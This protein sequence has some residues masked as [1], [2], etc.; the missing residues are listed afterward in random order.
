MQ[1]LLD[2]KRTTVKAFCRCHNGTSESKP[3]KPAGLNECKPTI[4]DFM[5]LEYFI[6][7]SHL[8]AAQ[9]K[10]CFIICSNSSTVDLAVGNY[11]R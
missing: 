2:G 8:S 9:Y 10:N 6:C 7:S 5:Y 4:Q 11:K 1:D 3:I